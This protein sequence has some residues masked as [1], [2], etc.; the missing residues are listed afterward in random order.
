MPMDRPSPEMIRIGSGSGLE[1]LFTDSSTLG[2]RT[3]Y[4]IKIRH[5]VI[6]AL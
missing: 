1:N 5:D 3:K 4:A 6:R 2:D